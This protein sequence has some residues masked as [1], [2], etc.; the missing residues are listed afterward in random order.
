[1]EGIVKLYGKNLSHLF[2]GWDYVEGVTRRLFDLAFQNQHQL[3]NLVLYDAHCIFDYLNTF[4]MPM[5]EELFL[6]CRTPSNRRLPFVKFN[7]PKLRRV[8]LH[9]PE[10][11]EDITPNSLSLPWS[12][13]THLSFGARIGGVDRWVPAGNFFSFL[14]QLP[15]LTY[16]HITG[17]VLPKR[18]TNHVMSSLTLPH[19]KFLELF[20]H[21]LTFLLKSPFLA[22]I[23]TPS[24][25]TF[26]VCFSIASS[27]RGGWGEDLR[28]ALVP[29]FQRTPSLRQ[30]RIAAFSSHQALWGQSRHDQ[31][32]LQLTGDG[33]YFARL[34][35]ATRV[36]RRHNNFARFAKTRKISTTGWIDG[37]VWTDGLVDRYINAFP[38][39]SLPS[40]PF[41]RSGSPGQEASGG[42]GYSTERG[43]GI[44]AQGEED[45]RSEGEGGGA[46]ASEI[47]ADLGLDVDDEGT[48]RFVDMFFRAQDQVH[49]EAIKATIFPLLGDSRIPD[50]IERHVYIF[51]G[52]L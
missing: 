52:S 38:I 42:P 16:L 31:H 49:L 20:D 6:W 28:E 30:I 35:Q 3:V 44:T 43:A 24:L 7:A 22:H 14:T 12:Q 29:F 1:M 41:V 18:G 2:L 40:D 11:C 10:A 51:L 9:L 4:D 13:I 37:E 23:S 39:T 47:H 25:D 33:P 46:S 45:G 36:G 19:L 15:R 17:V 26:D 48:E 50:H 5:L 32:M 21:S 8:F 27:P 34:S